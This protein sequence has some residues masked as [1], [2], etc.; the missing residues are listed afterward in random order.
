MKISENGTKAIIDRITPSIDTIDT[1]DRASSQRLQEEIDEA[2]ENG[3][4]VDIMPS[5]DEAYRNPH[6]KR[7]VYEHLE[8]IG[9]AINEQRRQ[10]MGNYA[11]LGT[12]GIAQQVA[13]GHLNRK[14]DGIRADYLYDVVEARPWWKQGGS[15]L[16]LATIVDAYQ[17]RTEDDP[18]DGYRRM[19][20]RIDESILQY[21]FDE[22]VPELQGMS[23]E[24][25][26]AETYRYFGLK[27][28][29]RPKP[30]KGV[31]QHVAKEKM[32]NL[33]EF[34]TT[35]N[36][37]GFTDVVRYCAD[38]IGIRERGPVVGDGIV[39]HVA[40]TG[41]ETPLIMSLGSGTGLPLFGMVETLA[42]QGKQ[43]KL[44]M[45][46][47]DPIALAVAAKEVERR[48]LE[49]YV[50]IHCQRV[51]SPTGKIIDFDDILQGRVPD[52]MENSGFREYVPDA[53]YDGLLTKINDI[54]PHGGLSVNC[55]TN[56]NRPQKGFLYGAMGWPVDIRCCTLQEMFDSIEQSGLPLDQTR[57]RVTKSGVYTAFTTVKH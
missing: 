34:V 5:S 53:V 44:I 49:D 10:T 30:S 48:Q 22:S 50:E 13:G 23:L 9:N 56:Q 40:E 51:F 28:I 32:A 36:T 1:I 42:Q 7:A 46:D 21:Q 3:Y 8:G 39:Q 37:E 6:K 2:R 31:R 27:G 20:G 43:P 35:K 57:A 45:V 55:C 18:T 12:D 24:Q 15:A 52:I 38:G 19:S 33:A 16:A 47:Q 41:S 14:L 26:T 25:A 29:V 11:V 17:L 4:V 54:L